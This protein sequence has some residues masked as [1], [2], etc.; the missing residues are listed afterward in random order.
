MQFIVKAITTILDQMRAEDAEF[1]IQMVVLS[2]NGSLLFVTYRRGDDGQ[3]L[4]NS[5]AEYQDQGQFMLPVHLI[6]VDATGE[7]FRHAILTDPDDKPRF[8]N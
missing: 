8:I 7:I 4:A 3:V 2:R 6:F 1:P 5:H